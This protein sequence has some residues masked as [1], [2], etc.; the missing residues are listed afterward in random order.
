[1]LSSVYPLPQLYS[2]GSVNRTGAVLKA[3]RWSLTH[4]MTSAPSGGAGAFA[5][6]QKGT[7]DSLLP[8]M[9]YPAKRRRAVAKPRPSVSLL[10][11]ELWSDPTSPWLEEHLQAAVAIYLRQNNFAFEIGMEGFRLSKSQR[12]KAKVQGMEA[13]RCDI[14]VLKPGGRTIHIEMKTVKGRL[15]AKQKDWH[16]RLVELGFEVHVVHGSCPQDAIDKVSEI[17][18]DET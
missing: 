15:S 16:K 10:K 6:N 4:S 2:D 17:L 3:P 12:A 7:C 14:K 8:I 11:R 1:M 5:L 13:G 18:A 9:T